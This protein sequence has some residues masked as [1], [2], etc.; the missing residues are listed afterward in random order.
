MSLPLPSHNA[1]M[2]ANKDDSDSFIDLDRL[3]ASAWRRRVMIAL[4]TA[5]F[6][7]LGVA[8]LVATVP[9][10]TSMT[11]ILLD[12][13][14]ARYTQEELA[15]AQS[16]QQVDTQISSAVEIL[17]SNKLALRVV[18]EAALAD[19][20]TILNP[21]KSVLE[22]AKSLPRSITGLFTD[23]VSEAS[24]TEAKRQK[25]AAM[26]QQSITV[27]RVGR[28][29]VV[30]L[31]YRSP[32]ARL[33]AKVANAYAAAYKADQLNANF[34]AAEGASIWL[35]E[36][37]DDLG[38]RAQTAA[39]EVERFKAE[40]GLTSTRGELMSEQQLTD[41]N[42]QLTI[43]QTDV[44]R[45][46]ARY[47]QFKSIV[48]QGASSVARNATVGTSDAGN[49]VLQD[50]RARYLTIE[51][52]EREVTGSFGTDHPQAVALKAE[53]DEIA[54][55]IYSEFQRLTESYRNEYEVARSREEA[56]RQRMEGVTGTNSIATQSLV[57]LR[58]LEQK[59]TSLRTLYQSYLE[60]FEQAN[61]NQTSTIPSAR[62]ISD[63]GVPV[64]PSSPKKTMVLALST[65]LGLMAGSA[66][67][68]AKEVQDR[69]FRLVRAI[70]SELGKTSLGYL[71]LVGTKPMTAFERLRR[72]VKQGG[73]NSP[74]PLPAPPLERM[75]RL[76]LEAPHSAFAETLR[77]V[78]L[79][80]DMNLKAGQNKVIGVV[81]SLPGE[82]KTTVATNFAMLLAASGK[83]TLLIDADLRKPRL[84]RMLKPAPKAGLVEAIAS[85]VAWT[86]LVRVDAQS[87]L[88]ILPIAPRAAGEQMPSSTELLASPRM[89]SLIDGARQH[90]EYVIVDLA[91]LGP[92]MDANVLS[93]QLDGFIF[94]VEWGK[95]PVQ[96]VTDLLDA[97]PLV[98][99]K[100]LGVLLNKTDMDLVSQY[101][102]SGGPEKYYGRY[103]GYYQQP[104]MTAPASTV[105]R[106]NPSVN[107]SPAP[108]G[109]PV[110]PATA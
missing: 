4:T 46:S 77:N 27:E 86:S 103:D 37:L 7:L 2:R 100:I 1:A 6:L 57:H 49:S 33:A 75:T 93:S 84:S 47:E 38:G 3:L 18:D 65:V 94:V 83:R 58:E 99:S 12:E 88:A 109:E 48:D 81:S 14:M 15:P 50:L 55:Q 98:A 17:K 31:S 95:T 63:A 45:A 82:G 54:Q 21:P 102:P 72:L 91:P 108:K 90:F 73:K 80:S 89:V 56:L 52:R 62:V 32:D 96:L 101:G 66:L 53:K 43:A 26:L 79:V 74:R 13:E 69:S 68:F 92:V 61:Q 110:S 40:N 41:L 20:D 104:I 36:R 23:E 19:N 11:Q 87:K 8:Y 44:A 97:Q 78:K 64:S 9:V 70:S 24:S 107:T 71:P 29:A 39:L 67:A 42:S 30:A 22:T 34:D 5:A 60:R 35:K 16:R 51:Q 76:V 105:G 59:A 28:S 10:Y 85:D 106:S 25:A